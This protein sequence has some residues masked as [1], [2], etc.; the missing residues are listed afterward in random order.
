VPWPVAAHDEVAAVLVSALDT[1]ANGAPII[2]TDASRI[3]RLRS[4]LRQRLGKAPFEQ[5]TAIGR[6]MNDHEALTYAR[7]Q[8]TPGGIPGTST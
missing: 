6:E 5:A 4:T 1:T 7:Q 2:G 3:S 8:A